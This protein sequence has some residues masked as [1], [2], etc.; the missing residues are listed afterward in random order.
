MF[1]EK[2]L[3]IELGGRTLKVSTGKIARQSNGAIMASYGDTVLLTA[4][5]RSKEP[6]DFCMEF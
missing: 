1:N 3:S 4:V 6:K 5:N 2:S